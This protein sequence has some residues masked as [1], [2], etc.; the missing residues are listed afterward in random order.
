MDEKSHLLTDLGPNEYFHP[1]IDYANSRISDFK[2]VK[3][4]E[5]S[6]LNREKNPRMPWHDVGTM[7]IGLP[8]KD[9][10]RHFMQYWNFIKIDLAD[11]KNLGVAHMQTVM[12]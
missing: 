10:A 5:T 8:V 1:G 3:F 7:V 4:P 2:N 11:R 12:E 9:L 6:H